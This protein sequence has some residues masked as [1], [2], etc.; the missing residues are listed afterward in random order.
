M[1]YK[2]NLKMESTAGSFRQQEAAAQGQAKPQYALKP[3]FSLRNRSIPKEEE[4]QQQP[5]QETLQMQFSKTASFQEKIPLKDRIQ[6]SDEKKNTAGAL[7]IPSKDEP[8]MKLKIDKNEEEQEKIPQQKQQEYEK[9][10]EQTQKPQ[11][12]Q[13]EQEVFDYKP[14]IGQ[15]QKQRDG[16]VLGS[17]NAIENKLAVASEEKVREQLDILEQ[18]MIVEDLD[19]VICPEGC[20]RQ[21]K[22]DVLEK[23]QKVCKQVFQQKRQ[24]FNSKQM[25]I[26]TQDQQ[27]LQRQGQ[28]KEKQLQKQSKG[29]P[30]EDPKWKK[31]SEE[32]RQ[33]AQKK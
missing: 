13:Q 30:P 25:R 18:A 29:K 4:P 17:K 2:P 3:T 26:V 23:H 1:F 24:E 21:F 27:K 12:K 8:V 7:Y 19:L 10:K 31:Q 6:R 9:E 33:L 32:L 28:I 14:S 20:G 11:Q 15:Q 5:V 16:A 22:P